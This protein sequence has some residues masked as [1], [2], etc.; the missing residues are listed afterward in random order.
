MS[1]VDRPGHGKMLGVLI[2]QEAATGRA[3]VLKA[4]SGQFLGDWNVPGWAP[5][6]AHLR[7]TSPRYA[8]AVSGIFAHSHLVS[9]AQADV[10]EAKT[11][12]AKREAQARLEAAR[13]ARRCKS[14]ELFNAIQRSYRLTGSDGAEA[15]I[16]E[17][18]FP[19]LPTP[20][21][22]KREGAFAAIP[23]GVGDC[24]APKVCSHSR[25][26]S[27]P[28]PQARPCVVLPSLIFLPFGFGSLIFLA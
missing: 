18:Y 17:A 2:C 7:H 24:V 25:S 6:L 5:P 4:F 12:T 8:A 10:A 22:G 14:H 15:T 21:S 9:T 3:L 13:E 19:A 16:K 11:A 20:A 1:S 26:A 28:L 27:M 23:A